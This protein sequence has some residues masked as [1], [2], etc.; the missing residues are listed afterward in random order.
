VTAETRG[1]F[2]DF[3]YYNSGFAMLPW[4]QVD[5]AVDFG[6]GY[7]WNPTVNIQMRN[8]NMTY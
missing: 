3:Y 6:E 5:A 4:E 8:S 2:E 7:S 1:S